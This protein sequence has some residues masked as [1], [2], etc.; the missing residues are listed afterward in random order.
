MGNENNRVKF[1]SMAD[2][3]SSYNLANAERAIQSYDESYTYR[4]VNDIIEFYNIQ[5]YFEKQ[6]YLK[7]WTDDMK[8]RYNSIVK[9][10]SKNIGKCFSQIDENNFIDY[11][12]SLVYEYVDDFWVLF[13]KYKLFNKI[14]AEFFDKILLLDKVEINDILKCK[15]IVIMYEKEIRKLFIKKIEYAET[16]I[17]EFIVAKDNNRIKYY[18]PSILTEEDKNQILLRY[19][20]NERANLNYLKIIYEAKSTKE[21]PIND[22]TRLKAKRRYDEETNKMFEND[23]GYRYGSQVSFR[24][25]IEN[26]KEVKLVNHIIEA[27]YSLDWVEENKDHPTLLNNF[28]YLFEF[29]DLQF[30]IQHV[31]KFNS[32]G[33]LEKVI[34]VKGKDEYLMGTAFSQIQGLALLQTISYYSQLLRMDIRLEAV[35]KWFFE[36][37]L[38]EEFHVNGFYLNLPSADSTYLEKCRTIASEIDS[39][40]KQYKLFVKEGDINSEL[41][42]LSSEHIF[43]K[44]IPSLIDNKYIY[45]KGKEYNQSTYYLFSDQSNLA[46]IAERKKSYGT[47][48][49]ML[50]EAHITKEELLQHQLINIEWLEKKGYIYCEKNG[51]LRCEAKK[52][53]LLKQLYDEEVLCRSYIEPVFKGEIDW[54]LKKEMVEFESS[55]L[56]RGEQDY[57]NYLLN[58][59]AFSNGLDLR[60]KYVHGT[61]TMEEK[62]QEQHYYTFLRVLVLIVIKINEEFCLTDIEENLSHP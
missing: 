36:F 34:R 15:H 22:K 58:K 25:E 46:Y 62:E 43:M 8:A 32:L 52:T 51:A 44:D 40:L 1:Y 47:L 6:M 45:P 2:L 24:K 11:Y 26:I 38:M 17:S 50:K 35:L 41:L 56:S 4:D 3:S 16:L 19:I 31:N 7:T 12:N 14:S 18:F 29:T 59:S 42:Q 55:L 60:N 5:L 28:I 53:V 27:S 39:I 20:E 10:F 61:Q 9:G 48:Y 57:F 49:R 21:F 54:F 33:T 37:Y 23:V 30:R 13:E